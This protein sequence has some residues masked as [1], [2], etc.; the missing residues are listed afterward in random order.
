MNHNTIDPRTRSLAHGVSRRT[1]LN[2]FDV[3][4]TALVV[5]SSPHR[6]D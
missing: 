1:V 4:L 6:R 3:N 2:R 5:V